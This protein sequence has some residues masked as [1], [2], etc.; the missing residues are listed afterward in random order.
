MIVEAETSTPLIS[1]DRRVLRA[2]LAANPS[3]LDEIFA[4]EEGGACV[5]VTVLRARDLAGSPHPVP[6][7][8]L[9]QEDAS[10]SR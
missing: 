9:E 6:L 10:S 3:L 1:I 8:W 5:A 4:V 7:L 2:A